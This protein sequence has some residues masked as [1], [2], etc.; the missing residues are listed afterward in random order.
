M[1]GVLLSRRL[2]TKT[3]FFEQMLSLISNISTQIRYSSD[4]LS[5]LLSRQE[6]ELTKSLTE[7]CIIHIE[8][9]ESFADGFCNE[10]DNLPASYGLKA[11]DKEL[12]KEFGRGLGVTD[13]EGQ[14]AH[15][16]LYKE[17]FTRRLNE[18]KEDRDKK[19]K[20][21]RS[22]GIFAGIS[23]ALLII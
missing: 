6:N 19:V 14:L 7:N 9:G 17:I 8:N 11:D 21:Y 2:I 23:L 18:V 1:A 16:G 4:A 3:K 15:C 5:V 12:L 10:V 13:V 20:L 22:L